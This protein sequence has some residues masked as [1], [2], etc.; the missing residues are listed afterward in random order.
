[1]FGAG[2]N[3]AQLGV[4]TGLLAPKAERVGARVPPAAKGSPVGG[5]QTE[6]RPEAD[7]PVETPG[8][9][10]ASSTAK[11][12]IA[13]DVANNAVVVHAGLQDAILIERAIRDLDRA[14]V[15]VAIEATI[16]E[17][18]LNNALNNGVQFYLRGKWG[19]IS[20]SNDQLPLGR[21]VPGLNL[22]LGNEASPRFVLD[23]LRAVTEVKILSSPSLVVVNN[24]PAVLQ[25]GDQVPITT[26]TAQA[27]VDPLAPI[28]NSIDFRD[29][30]VILR[31]TPQVNADS[32][33][34]IDVDQEISAVKEASTDAES[35][36]PTISQRRVKST[37]S[38]A[39]GQTLVLAGLISEQR[40]KGKSGTPGI[41]DIPIVGNILAGRN[42]DEKTR[43]ELIIFIKPQVVRN[44]IDARLVAEGL[45]QRMKG[46]ERW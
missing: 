25:V 39:D 31:I 19:A 5:L 17:I 14:P 18:T 32:M 9:D 12:R 20:Q 22:V 8:F 13:S 4:E 23:A 33:V 44:M 38:V 21:V 28:V 30:G 36:T 1:M 11:I 29:T 10:T 2:G 6:G 26:R 46:F 41:I 15:Q 7:A 24:Q 3:N 35:L 43:T 34:R 40:S 16:A 27:V 37:V 45:R 42:S